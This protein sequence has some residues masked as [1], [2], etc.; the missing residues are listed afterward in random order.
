MKDTVANGLFWLVYRDPLGTCTCMCVCVCVFTWLS[1]FSVLVLKLMSF[2]S[3]PAALKPFSANSVHYKCMF[4]L[5]L[6]HTVNISSKVPKKIWQ[7]GHLTIN[8]QKLCNSHEYLFFFW[9][10]GFL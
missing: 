2:S 6:H 4:N 3:L 5:Q 1:L 8:L 7:F 10:G 9:G